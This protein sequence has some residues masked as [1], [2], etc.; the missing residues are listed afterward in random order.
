MGRQKI[1]AG[2]WKMNLLPTEAK[3]LAETLAQGSAHLPQD[4]TVI[5][6]PSHIYLSAVQ[7][8]IA[9]TNIKI[10]AQNTHFEKSGA[11][12]GEV[13]PAML[14]AMG[15]EYVIIGHSERRDL[16]GENNVIIQN[17]VKAALAEGLNVILCCGESLETREAQLI[18]AL[19][20]ITPEQ[21]SHIVLAYEPIWAIGTGK[22][23]TAEQAQSM[24]AHIRK[25]IETIYNSTI[26][27][28]TSILYGGSCKPSNA[29]EIFANPDVDGGLIGGAA[30]VAQ[31]FEAI[32][33][34]F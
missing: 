6:C 1:V 7:Q 16:F 12:T 33:K 5:L 26:A 15:I 17:K 4:V 10:G 30:L 3:Q 22:T 9:G 21:M 31:D 32:I 29:Q 2:N 19:T 28:N 34:S 20:G 25:V 8:C 11:Y 23:A 14:K 27:Q 24:H 13:S 18:D